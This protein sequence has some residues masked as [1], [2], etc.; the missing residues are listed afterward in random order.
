MDAKALP[1]LTSPDGR[2]TAT[3]EDAME[4]AMGGPTFG[5]LTLSNGMF[6]ESCN[7]SMVWSEDSEYLAVPQWTKE[8][9]QRLLVISVV[10]RSARYAPSEYRVLE[11]RAFR[12]GKIRGIDSPIFMPQAIEVDVTALGWD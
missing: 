5:R 3:I 4:I 11:L 1:T 12:N 10:R 2:T 9:A 7:P 8:R 6:R